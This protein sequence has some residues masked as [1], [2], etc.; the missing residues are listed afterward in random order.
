MRFLFNTKHFA[1]AQMITPLLP[2]LRCIQDLMPYL[3]CTLPILCVPSAIARCESESTSE[4]HAHA[5]HQAAKQGKA[6]QSQ[7]EH[8]EGEHV[9]RLIA[10]VLTGLISVC[11]KLR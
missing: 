3:S 2:S 4:C 1:D 7:Y 6:R 9:G 8:D 10:A 5:D 11:F